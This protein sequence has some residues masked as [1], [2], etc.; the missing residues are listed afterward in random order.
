MLT[1]AVLVVL[2]MLGAALLASVWWWLGSPPSH[3]ERRY[4]LHLARRLAQRR[5]DALIEQGMQRLLAEA[6]CHGN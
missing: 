3:F 4:R 5:V 1:A 2:L 6:R